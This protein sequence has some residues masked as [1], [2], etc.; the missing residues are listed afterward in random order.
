MNLFD[1]SLGTNIRAHLIY[2]GIEKPI[3]S[4]SYHLTE[5]EH[6][7]QIESHLSHIETHLNQIND[8]MGV[9]ISSKALAKKIYSDYYGQSYKNFPKSNIVLEH[10]K[11]SHLN[12]LLTTN[13]KCP[14]T[15]EKKPIQI[16]I[17]GNIIKPNYENESREFIKSVIEFFLHR[18]Y[19]ESHFK[20]CLQ[21]TFNFIYNSEVNIEIIECL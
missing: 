17:Y 19:Q 7:A 5:N 6:I 1:T 14:N 3:A 16:N 10:D 15:W 13:Y 12:F 20:A 2:K 9:N 8:I 4:K 18:P 11:L 21:E